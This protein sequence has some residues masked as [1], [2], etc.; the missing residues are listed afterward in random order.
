MR[1]TTILKVTRRDRGARKQWLA[2]AV[3]VLA[4]LL[5]SACA[6]SSAPSETGD[7]R[8]AWLQTLI[9]QIE[10]EPV[11]NPPSAIYRYQ[12]KGATVYFR[13]SRCC[14]IRSDVYDEAGTVI[15][16]PDGGIT[17]DGDR[18]CTDFFASRTGE[19]LVW[20]DSRKQEG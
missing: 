7:S 11:T 6:S 20:Q 13:P 17:G 19:R 18:R 1:L 16:H 4:A 14:D 10:A 5:G 2:L 12:Y 15:C 8:P 3:L 9:A